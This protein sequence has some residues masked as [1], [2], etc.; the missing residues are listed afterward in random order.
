MTPDPV[1]KAVRIQIIL[2][3]AWGENDD[4][5]GIHRQH[6]GKDWQGSGILPSI[7]EREGACKTRRATY[8]AQVGLRAGIWSCQRDH[9]VHPEP[10]TRKEENPRRCKEGKG[11]EVVVK[12]PRLAG[13]S[14]RV[15]QLQSAAV[16][17]VPNACVLVRGA[18]QSSPGE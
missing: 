10:G 9:L 12:T 11:Q 4:I 18:A 2:A 17:Q 16:G 15:R 8:M 7:G 13:G 1:K 5:Q 14:R 3:D 6:Q